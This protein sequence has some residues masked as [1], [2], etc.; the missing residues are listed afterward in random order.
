MGSNKEYITVDGKKI[1]S[2][3]KKIEMRY[4]EKTGLSKGTKIYDDYWKAFDLSN[5]DFNGKKIIEVGCGPFGGIFYNH[6]EYDVS[7]VDFCSKEYNK[8]GY[9]ERNIQFGDLNKK[10]IFPDNEFHFCICT[11]TIDHTKD[12]KKSLLEIYRV[13]CDGGLLFL[14]VHLRNKKELNHGHI[15]PLNVE[16]VH[17]YIRSV[18]FSIQKQEQCEDWVNKKKNKNRQ[19]LFL[20]LKK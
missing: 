2:W 12:V 11:N 9:S 18:E 1:L 15:H 17:E 14:H 16:V 7:L 5:Y 20:T 8:L 6:P 4:W 10:L 19:A 13:L 3:S